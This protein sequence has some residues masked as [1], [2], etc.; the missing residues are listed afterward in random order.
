MRQNQGMAPARLL[1]ILCVSLFLAVLFGS[2]A[3]DFFWVRSECERRCE[4]HGGLDHAWPMGW[5]TTRFRC[6]DGDTQTLYDL[7]WFPETM[8]DVF[9]GEE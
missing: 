5:A 1:P 4:S 2:M 6:Q 7:E 8:K 9:G 3:I